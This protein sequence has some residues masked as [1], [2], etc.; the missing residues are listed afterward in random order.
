MLN[1]TGSVVS[2][3]KGSQG[4]P[5]SNSLSVLLLL[6]STKSARER[7]PDEVVRLPDDV[8][9]CRAGATAWNAELG[10]TLLEGSA[11][12]RAVEEPGT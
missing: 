3:T 7:N 1:L 5:G 10:P 9:G 11:V 4:V 2:L 8:R 12:A 6:N